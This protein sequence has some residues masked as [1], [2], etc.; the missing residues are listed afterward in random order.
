MA[1]GKKSKTK[2]MD[3]LKRYRRCGVLDIQCEH[4][5]ED[6]LS[7]IIAVDGKTIFSEYICGDMS[8]FESSPDQYNKN[9]DESID[10]LNELIDVLL[11]VRQ[12]MVNAKN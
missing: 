12:F 9:V 7:A 2:E 6:H 3:I 5:P 1:K 11:K 4:E 8:D 10:G